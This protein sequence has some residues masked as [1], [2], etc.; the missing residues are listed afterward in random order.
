ML[1]L[2]MSDSKIATSSQV[3][4]VINLIMAVFFTL[5]SYANTNDDDWYVWVPIYTVP[6]LLSTSAVIKPSCTESQSWKL[7]ISLDFALCLL[8]GVYQMIALCKVMANDLKNPLIYEEGREM[9]GLFII[10]CW[11]G[12]TRFFLF[13]SNKSDRGSQQLITAIFWM[14]IF[15]ALIPL[16]L[17]SLC[18][19]S[20]WHKHFGH[21]NSMF[22]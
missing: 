4:R 17:W 13:R 6:A 20:D 19:I 9:V 2:E 22:K 11:T 15:L 8:Y 14:T 1:D 12:A 5:A 21:C 3:W 7:V 18:F 16:F 10:L